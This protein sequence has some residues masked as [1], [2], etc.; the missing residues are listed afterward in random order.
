MLASG[1]HLGV[2]DLKWWCGL[3]GR[4]TLVVWWTVVEGRAGPWG[5]WLPTNNGINGNSGFALDLD[6]LVS[7]LR[8]CSM[9]D[10]YSS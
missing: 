7:G 9:I 4:D 10:R 3:L 8:G 6:R 5:D 2:D 1:A